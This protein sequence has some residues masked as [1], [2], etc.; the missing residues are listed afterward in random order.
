MVLWKWKTVKPI[1]KKIRDK[2][3]IKLCMEKRLYI[4]KLYEKLEKMK[5]FIQII[6][7]MNGL[8]NA[9]KI[10]WSDILEEN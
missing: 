8:Q 3:D 10:N 7:C 6:N 2:N 4:A 1:K 9:G 5:Y